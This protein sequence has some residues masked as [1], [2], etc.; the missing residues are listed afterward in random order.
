MASYLAAVFTIA[1]W[2][3]VGCQASGGGAGPEETRSS[4]SPTNAPASKG[5]VPNVPEGAVPQLSRAKQD[6]E[7]RLGI[8]SESIRVVKVE[9]AEWRDSSLGC[10]EPGK[11]YAQVITPGYR[12]VLEA[13][14]K[15]YEYHTD[16]RNA[17]VL[18]SQ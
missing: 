4:P 2:L 10:P 12:V 11:M 15:T 17:V 13:Q 6:L 18:C 16:T 8:P 3:I 9:E 7:R 14:G 5:S 1:F